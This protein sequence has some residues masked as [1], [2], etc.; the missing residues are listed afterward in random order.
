VR[1][2]VAT[3]MTLLS[4]PAGG[5]RSM[6]RDGSRGLTARE[7]EHETAAVLIHWFGD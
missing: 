4:F 3:P 6:M 2:L 1:T 5:D 7:N